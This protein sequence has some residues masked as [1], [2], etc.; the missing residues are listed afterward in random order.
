[1]HTTPGNVFLRLEPN[2]RPI[3]TPILARPF[4]SRSQHIK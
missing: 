2:M 1:V 4:F 3:L